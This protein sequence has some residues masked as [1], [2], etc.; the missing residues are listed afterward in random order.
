MT[1]HNSIATRCDFAVIK[2]DKICG[3]R[4][5]LSCDAEHCNPHL[6]AATRYKHIYLFFPWC[7]YK[8]YVLA[9]C[10]LYKISSSLFSPAFQLQLNRNNFVTEIYL[11]SEREQEPMWVWWSAVTAA[12]AKLINE[13]HKKRSN[14][15]FIQSKLIGKTCW[16]IN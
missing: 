12:S 1:Q 7:A 14:I 4:F 16:S 9:D 11:F 8:P 15:C 2:T 5:L 10:P 6:S 3:H 13:W